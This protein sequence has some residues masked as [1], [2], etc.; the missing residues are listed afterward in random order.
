MT[1]GA[2]LTGAEAGRVAENPRAMSC[3]RELAPKVRGHLGD[4]SLSCGTGLWLT[5]EYQGDH[6][7]H[8]LTS[9]SVIAAPLDIYSHIRHRPALR[10]ADAKARPPS[11]RHSPASRRSRAALR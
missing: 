2:V 6:R 10:S 1:F 9:T 11:A 8:H 4:G 3:D 7:R 5:R